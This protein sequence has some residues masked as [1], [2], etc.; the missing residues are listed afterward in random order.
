MEVTHIVVQRYKS[1]MSND[2]YQKKKL[3]ESAMTYA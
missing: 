2:Q 1:L 3:K